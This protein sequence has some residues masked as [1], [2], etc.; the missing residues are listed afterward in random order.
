MRPFSI[1]ANFSLNLGGV[2]IGKY[3]DKTGFIHPLWR[4][5]KSDFVLLPIIVTYKFLFVKYILHYGIYILHK[6][7]R[8]Q[9]GNT[10]EKAQHAPLI[11]GDALRLPESLMLSL[12]A[13]ILE[14]AS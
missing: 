7:R 14:A 2:F 5:D 10:G 12:R 1:L 8:K 3:L 9:G 6:L 13:A 11:G 4:K